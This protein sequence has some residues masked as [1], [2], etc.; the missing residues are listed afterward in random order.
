LALDITKNHFTPD[1]A[2]EVAAPDRSGLGV[3]IDE[4]TLRPY[5]QDVEI[6]VKGRSLY[7]TPVLLG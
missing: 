4:Q 7:R 1:G 6:T 5:L 3:E 2:G